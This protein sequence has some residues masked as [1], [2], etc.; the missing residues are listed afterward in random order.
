MLIIKKSL[1]EIEKF[2]VSIN[3]LSNIPF[4]IGKMFLYIKYRNDRKRV[5][6]KLW[7]YIEGDSK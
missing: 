6:Q 3:H 5:D 4:Q 2:I 7:P 1:I